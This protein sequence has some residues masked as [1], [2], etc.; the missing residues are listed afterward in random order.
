[1]TNV[2]LWYI[3]VAVADLVFAWIGLGLWGLSAERQIHK[4]RIIMFRNIIRQEIGW[5]DTHSSGE[6]GTKLTE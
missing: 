2:A 1:M 5:F 3:G 6:L 4:M